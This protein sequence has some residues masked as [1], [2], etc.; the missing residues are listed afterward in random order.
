MIRLET[1][2]RFV[3]LHGGRFPGS[4]V[5]L[6]HQ[7]YAIAVSIAQSRSHAPL[8]FAQVVIPAI[9]Q[10]RN[11]AVDGASHDPDCVVG[12]FRDPQVEPPEPNG[13][14]RFTRSA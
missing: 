5:E 10:E 9:V 13:R 6:S 2:Q 12:I 7:E 11:A 14:N 8:A 1:P 3:D 4:P